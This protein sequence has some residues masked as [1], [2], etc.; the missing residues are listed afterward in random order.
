[1]ERKQETVI[2]LDIDGVLQHDAYRRF[3]LR[4]DWN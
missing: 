1:M 3:C 4:K 2:F